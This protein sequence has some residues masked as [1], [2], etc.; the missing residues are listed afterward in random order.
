MFFGLRRQL[1]RH[2]LPVLAIA[3]ILTLAALPAAVSA[4]QGPGN[5]LDPI[6]QE[7]VDLVNQERERAGV[8]PLIVN[9]SLQEAAWR[10]TEHMADRK[11]MCHEGCGDG[12]PWQRISATGYQFATAGENVASGQRSS[13]A[14][15]RAWMNSS[16]HRANILNP[17]YTD[18]GVA[19]APAGLYG[20][21]WT[22]VFARPK[23]DYVTVT[24][25]ANPGEDPPGC[26]NPLDVTGDCKVD[27][28]DLDAVMSHFMTRPGHTRWD[29]KYDVVEDEVVNIYDVF[30]VALAMAEGG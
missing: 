21:S 29:E 17:A 10:H 3:S 20:T 13:T 30:A 19:F 24:P 12:T 7:V 18:I 28:A 5:P 26:E 25:P 15:M 6:E 16:R 11:V 9:F 2:V 23:S 1:A 8:P 4:W 14:V 22:Q 27:Q